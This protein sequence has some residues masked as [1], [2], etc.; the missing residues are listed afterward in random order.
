MSDGVTVRRLTSLPQ[1]DVRFGAGDA[2]LVQR[3]ADAMTAPP[4]TVP[5]TVTAAT[6]GD[7]H[8]L[9]L[10]PDEWLVVGLEGRG[11]EV[12]PEIER[13]LHDAA[14]DAFLTTVDVSANR[15]GL[16]V[17][18]PRTRDLLAFGCSLDL[19]DR[20]FPTGTCAQTNV[21]RANVILWR[22]EDEVWWLLVRPSFVGYLQAWLDD[23]RAGLG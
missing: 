8:W 2:A 12:G 15:V 18:G 21:A 22:R 14:G 23:A 1:V 11:E 16:E 17:A 6:D 13:V 9:W 20:A 4:P 19:D 5:N 10:G 3:L 7:G